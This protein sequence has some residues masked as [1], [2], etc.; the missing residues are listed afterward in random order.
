MGPET[1]SLQR[2]LRAKGVSRRLLHENIATR[3]PSRHRQEPGIQNREAQAQGWGS[4]GPRIGHLCGGRR[5]A[6]S[7]LPFCP[8]CKGRTKLCPEPW[9]QSPLKNTVPG[10]PAPVVQVGMTSSAKTTSRCPTHVC[11]DT[12]SPGSCGLPRSP[13]V[14]SFLCCFLSMKTGKKP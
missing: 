7:P 11:G 14:V 4:P 3:G 10:P 12:S 1:R 9:G 6:S 13:Q 5:D 8:S 2:S